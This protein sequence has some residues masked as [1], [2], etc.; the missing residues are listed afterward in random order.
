MWRWIRRLALGLIGLLVLSAIGGAIY[1]WYSTRR[2]LAETPPP[3]R[4]VDVGGHRLHIWCKGS[5]TPT[6][7]FDAGLGDTS[8]VWSVV[9]DE[10]ATFTR[11]C[12]YD[13]AGSGYSDA[14]PSPRN[15]LQFAAEL[16][17]LLRQSHINDPVVLAGASIGGLYVRILASQHPERAAGLVLVDASHENQ[18]VDMPPFASLVPVA[19]S[20]GVLRLLGVSLGRNPESLPL[21]VQGFERATAFRTS[22]YLALYDEV[23]QMAESAS[24]VRASRRELTMPLVVV[25]SG[26]GNRQASWRRFQQDQV[27]LSRRGCQIVAEKSGHIIAHDAPKIV[28]GAIRATVAASKTASTIPCDLLHASTP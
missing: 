14:G 18:G 5:G 12:A 10:V 16:E 1:Q 27:R 7:I 21:S 22:R 19:G 25:T 23:V 4:L 24:Q 9:Q 11:A 6:V 17:Q 2:D 13:R 20:L 8:F 3:G 26:R 28:A 15:A